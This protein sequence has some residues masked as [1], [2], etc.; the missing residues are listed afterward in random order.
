MDIASS[1]A[2]EA[3]KTLSLQAPTQAL[4]NALEYSALPAGY[5]RTGHSCPQSKALS[6]QHNNVVT[7]LRLCRK[8]NLTSEPEQ[9][10]SKLEAEGLEASPTALEIEYPPIHELVFASC[11]ETM[12]NNNP[13]SSFQALQHII[14]FHFLFTF[15][16]TFTSNATTVNKTSLYSHKHNAAKE[17][18]SS[19]PSQHHN[20]IIPNSK[21][22]ER[23]I[24]TSYHHSLPSTHNTKTIKQYP[25]PLPARDREID[26]GIDIEEKRREKGTRLAPNILYDPARYAR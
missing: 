15:T 20:P 2:C 22:S 1:V 25:F 8:L 5:P 4:V 12:H 7:I 6:E 13:H 10:I 14:S 26:I 23:N 18:V 17:G 19:V 16:F 11:H 21:A 3:S 24:I 9:A